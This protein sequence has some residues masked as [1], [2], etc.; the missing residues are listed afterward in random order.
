M[1]KLIISAYDFGLSA[2]V[3]TGIKLAISKNI[4]TEIFVLANGKSS[5]GAAE[6]LKQTD[7][8]AS[9]CLN[10]SSLKPL[11]SDVK[12]LVDDTGRFRKPDLKTWNYDF[13]SSVSEAEI[14][15]EIYGS[16]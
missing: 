7:I 9:L 13:L 11:C 16:V 14:K 4:V 5:A 15:R 2:S 3:D 10:I 1:K 6:F 8:S 12:T